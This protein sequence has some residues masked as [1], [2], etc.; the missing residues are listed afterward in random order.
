MVDSSLHRNYVF[1]INS[2]GSLMNSIIKGEGSKRRMDAV[3]V[4]IV[5]FLNFESN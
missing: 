5:V 2:F 3:D 4:F 1:L